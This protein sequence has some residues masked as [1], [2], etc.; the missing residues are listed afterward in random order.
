MKYESSHGHFSQLLTNEPSSLCSKQP[1]SC[2][3]P[4]LLCQ[5]CSVTPCWNNAVCVTAQGEFLAVRLIRRSI[6][7]DRPLIADSNDHTCQRALGANSNMCPHMHHVV[8]IHTSPRLHKPRQSSKNWTS[9]ID[10][11]SKN[12]CWMR[13]LFSANVMWHLA[14]ISTSYM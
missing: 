3:Q 8:T 12:E 5:V 1:V 6:R 4:R 10:P 13:V 7:A 11:L 2:L 14:F 9:G